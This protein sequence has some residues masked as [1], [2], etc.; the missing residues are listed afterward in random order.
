M[1]SDKELSGRVFRELDR[2]GGLTRRSPLF[3]WLR[4]HYAE[5]AERLAAAGGP[6]SVDWPAVAEALGEAGLRDA[7]GKPPGA[8]V[9]RKTW[10]KV[11]AM[12][13]GRPK[14]SASVSSPVAPSPPAAQAAPP[15]SGGPGMSVEAQLER[16]RATLRAGT[17]PLPSKVER[18]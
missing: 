18:R 1:S 8:Q 5:M 16:A 4:D 10:A 11:V 3:L 13:S 6:R 17:V 9:A 2:R 15:G 12:M 14:A 7:D